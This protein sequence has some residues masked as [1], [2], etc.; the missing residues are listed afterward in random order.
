MHKSVN[1]QNLL[2]ARWDCSCGQSHYVPVRKVVIEEDALKHLPSIVEQESHGG[3]VLIISDKITHEIAGRKAAQILKDQGL[4]LRELVVPFEEPVADDKTAEW[5]ARQVKDEALLISCG[6]GTITDLTK[7]AAF[8]KKIPFVAVATAPSMNGYASGVVAVTEK[9]LKKTIP[10]APSVA[11][12]ADLNILCAAPLEMILSGLG[13]VMSKP[14]CMADWK[15][16]SIIKGETFCPI[17]YKII[18]DLESVYLGNSALIKKRDPKVIGALTEALVFSGIS[19]VIAGSSA[20]ASG[21]EHLISHTLDMQA[22]LK[23]KKHDFHGTQVGVA[24]I[25]TARLYEKVMSLNPKE[26]DFEDL[27][28]HFESANTIDDI[29]KYW[30]PLAQEVMKEYE[31]KLMPWASKEEELRSIVDRWDDI[32]SQA[33]DLLSPSSAIKRILTEAGAKAHYS[34]LGVTGADFKRALLMARTMRSRYT[35]LDLA[36]DLNLL[37]PFAQETAGEK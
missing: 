35:I 37:E 30:G 24:T 29:K 21:G 31:K 33:G 12:V 19:M 32:R 11:V 36:N 28:R 20:P 15:L 17:P 4:N 16:A 14:V 3:R 25:V 6:S 9:G 27:R 22:W 10:V 5:V 1:R 2:G 18:K 34:D 8:K 7:Y 13:D 26:L 23:G